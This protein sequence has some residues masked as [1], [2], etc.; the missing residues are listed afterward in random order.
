MDRLALHLTKL[1]RGLETSKCC[2]GGDIQALFLQYRS[3]FSSSCNSD[4]D[5]FVEREPSLLK[6]LNL[7]IKWQSHHGGPARQGRFYL[8]DSGLWNHS[9]RDSPLNRRAWVL[10]ERLLAPRVLHFGKYLFWECKSMAASEVMPTGKPRQDS[11]GHETFYPRLIQIIEQLSTMEDEL[12]DDK[13]ALTK[14]A[15]DAWWDLVKKYSSCQ[16]TK[17]EDILVAIYGIASLMEKALMDQYVGGLW[18]STLL[19]DLLWRPYAMRSPRPTQPFPFR[20]STWSWASLKGQVFRANDPI[21]DAFY[22]GACVFL[23]EIM[24]VRIE[25]AGAERNGQLKN[26]YLS[27]LG[28]TFEMACQETDFHGDELS[29]KIGHYTFG[30]DMYVDDFDW[31]EVFKERRGAD[32]VCMPILLTSSGGISLHGLVIEPAPYGYPE[33]H[34]VRIGVFICLLQAENQPDIEEFRLKIEEGQKRRTIV[35][36]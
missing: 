21:P 29:F 10:Q 30:V 14:S 34:F 5:I 19:E 8:W 36:V 35:L 1:S 6:P 9:V 22:N 18:R 4:G 23:S 7:A 17:D 28:L 16:L 26:G 11:C 32:V 27:V 33:E 31:W 13:K 24:D 12:S 25:S 15:H 3:Y 2:D 20:A